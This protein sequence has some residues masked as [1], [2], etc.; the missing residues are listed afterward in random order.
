MNTTTLTTVFG[1]VMAGGF[2]TATYLQTQGNIRDPLWWIGLV[3]AVAAALKG[4]YTQ[5]VQKP[6]STR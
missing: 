6:E 4:Y 5:G 3:T 2:A 1:L